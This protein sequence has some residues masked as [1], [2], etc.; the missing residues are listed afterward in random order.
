MTNPKIAF[1]G[2]GVMGA[3]MAGHLID[4]GY[5]VT[6]YNRTMHK[7][8]PLV[9]RGAQIAS[10]LAVP[11]SLESP[12]SVSVTITSNCTESQKS[13]GAIAGVS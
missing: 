2:T 5:P 10:R 3:A 12:D 8:L 4:A 6:V 11:G 1:I 7:A 13:A 9:D